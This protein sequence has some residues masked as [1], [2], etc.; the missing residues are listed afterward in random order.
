MEKRKQIMLLKSRC[1]GPCYHKDQEGWDYNYAHSHPYTQ[2]AALINQATLYNFL[3]PE[4]NNGNIPDVPGYLQ[5][6]EGPSLEWLKKLNTPA[7]GRD[8]FPCCP[9]NKN[10]KTNLTK[11]CRCPYVEE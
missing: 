9:H 4:Q 1:T 5:D 10:V 3:V 11:K 8:P 6:P 2:S 7:D